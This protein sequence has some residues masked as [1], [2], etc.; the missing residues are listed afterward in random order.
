MAE[1]EKKEDQNTQSLGKRIT[2]QRRKDQ[3]VFF[4]SQDTNGTFVSYFVDGLYF[5]RLGD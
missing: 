3:R 1:L 2:R 4:P 5:Q